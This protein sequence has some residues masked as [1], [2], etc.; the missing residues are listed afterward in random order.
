MNGHKVVILTGMHRSGTSLAAQWMHRCGL[1]LGEE[2]LGAHIGNNDGHFEDMDF[3]RLHEKILDELKL[4]TT[5]LIATPLPPLKQEQQ[6]A[7]GELIRQKMTVKASWGWKEPRTCLFLPYYQK[8]LPSAFYLILIRDYEMV[9]S[10][11]ILRLF[12]LVEKKIRC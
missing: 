7:L 12:K 2:L 5:G 11:L 10:S 1:H 9:V 6:Q 3:L 4:P 8:I